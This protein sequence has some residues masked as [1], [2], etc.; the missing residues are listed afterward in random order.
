M[1]KLKVVSDTQFK[2]RPGLSNELSRQDKVFVPNGTEFDL[3]NSDV[4]QGGHLKVTLAK[5]LGPANKTVWYVR[6]EE[7]TSELQSCPHISYAVF[8]LKK[9]NN[10]NNNNIRQIL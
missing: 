1:K 10:N 7:H 2:L 6:S 5:P 9:K 3:T 8:C 4:V